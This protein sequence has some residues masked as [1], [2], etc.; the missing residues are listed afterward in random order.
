MFARAAFYA[1]LCACAC[2]RLSP[3]IPVLGDTWHDSATSCYPDIIPDNH[4]PAWCWM[5]FPTARK[6]RIVDVSK[7][8]RCHP[9]DQVIAT[10]KNMI[11]SCNGCEASNMQSSALSPSEPVN[12]NSLVTIRES[13]NISV[14]YFTIVGS[15]LGFSL[16]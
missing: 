12:H 8:V 4:I 10:K 7:W 15:R 1:N 6:S 3:P 5:P 13:S 14:Y 9:V 16:A 2:M 11:A